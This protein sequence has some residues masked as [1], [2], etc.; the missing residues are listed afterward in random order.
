L[1][2]WNTSDELSRVSFYK[3]HARDP[4]FFTDGF[5]FEWRNGDV[6]DPATGEKCTALTGNLIAKPTAANV[7]SLVYAYTW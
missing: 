4:I 5:R 6:A 3:L 1:T 2:V 7:S